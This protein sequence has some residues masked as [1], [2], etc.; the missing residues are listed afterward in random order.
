MSSVGTLISGKRER[1]VDILDVGVDPLTMDELL[2]LVDECIASREQLLLGVVN[3]A[4]VVNARRD[5]K[6]RQSLEQASLVLADGVPII[7]LSKLMGTSLPERIAGIDLMYKLLE[8]SCQMRYG[9]YFLGAKPDVVER[10]VK[11]VRSNY[12]GLRVAGFR[13]GYFDKTDEK[14]VSEGIKKSGADILFIGI[15]SPKKEK[16]LEEWRDYMSVPIC[17]GVGGSFDIL[18]GVTKR[19]P[20]WMQ[21]CGLEWFYRFVQEPRRMWKRYLVTNTIFIKLGFKAIIRARLKA[22]FRKHLFKPASSTREPE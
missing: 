19:A 18:A 13:D 10:V 11:L 12:P 4:K 9:V 2:E 20:V 14:E 7:W 16:F 5:R 17:H 21:K 6:L 3:A 15:S 1:A 22:V 8:R